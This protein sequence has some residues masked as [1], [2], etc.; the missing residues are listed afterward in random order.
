MGEEDL[1]EIDF[2]AVS[3]YHGQGA[4]AMLAVTFRALE[5]ALKALSPDQAPKRSDITIVSGPSGSRRQGLVR[6]RDT[7]RHARRLHGGSLIAGFEAGAFRRPVLQLSRHA[8]RQDGRDRRAAERLARAVFRADLQ[9]VAH[10]GGG[11]RGPAIAKVDRRRRARGVAR[12]AVPA[13]RCLID[14][15]GTRA[16]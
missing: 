8:G 15:A 2:A 10:R 3:A 5:V 6:I 9:S 12:E 13:A 14:E 4:L 16:V 1:I 11:D 7:R